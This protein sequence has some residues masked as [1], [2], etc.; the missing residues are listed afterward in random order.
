[1]YTYIY[2]EYN[3]Y[4]HN[5]RDISSPDLVGACIYPAPPDIF[6]R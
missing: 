5:A 3:V 4:F 1:M 2:R 6:Y